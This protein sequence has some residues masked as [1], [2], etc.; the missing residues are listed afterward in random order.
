MTIHPSSDGEHQV[1][2]LFYGYLVSILECIP[3]FAVEYMK[4]GLNYGMDGHLGFYSRIKLM[5]TNQA[6]LDSNQR[7]LSH[8]GVLLMKNL[9]RT[10]QGRID[11]DKDYRLFDEYDSRVMK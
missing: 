11:N 8:D 2:I 1:L 7:S 10:L 9:K 5:K 3:N 6:S 4:D